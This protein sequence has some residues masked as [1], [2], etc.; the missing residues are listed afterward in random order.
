ME[1]GIVGLGLIGGSL[2]LDLCDRGHTVLGISRSPDTC[3]QAVLRGAV[4]QASS[5]M[6]LLAEA[7]VIFICTPLGVMPQTVAALIPH[8]SQDTILTDVGSVKTFVVKAIEPLWPHFVGGHPMSGTEFTGIQ[9]AQRQL[10]VGNPYVLT[11]TAA[12]SSRSLEQVRS[13]VYELG[14]QLYVCTPEQHDR[15]VAWISHLPTMISATLIQACLSEPDP[16]TRALAQS[17]ASSGFRDTSRVGG[18]NPQLGRMM[19][20]FNQAEVL[21]SLYRY[22][23]QLHSTI[24][25][26]EAS[27]WSELETQFQHNQAERPR[28]LKEK[29]RDG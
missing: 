22:R 4:H 11:P 1:I 18:G 12:T 29:P 15:A 21:R 14:S 7:A 20:Q 26:L 5:D 9:A 6:A 10:F 27:Q 2:G 3:T 17:L 16:E 8:L 24:S 25:A 19:A 23:D 28:F 13:L